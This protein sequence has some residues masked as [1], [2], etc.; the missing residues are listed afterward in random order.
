MIY[1]SL[2]VT[3]AN[4]DKGYFKKFKEFGSG[5]ISFFTGGGNKPENTE[6][7]L[8]TASESTV[9]IPKMEDMRKYCLDIYLEDY[10]LAFKT[11]INDMMVKPM[12]LIK[13]IANI[14]KCLHAPIIHDGTP[15][16]SGRTREWKCPNLIHVSIQF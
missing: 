10:L 3:K 4:E 6:N 7:N 16:S 8:E 12:K 5:L 2:F 14:C 1:P 13:D 9:E 11:G 15:K